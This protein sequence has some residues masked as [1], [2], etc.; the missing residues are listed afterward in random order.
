VPFSIALQFEDDK[1]AN[2]E[3]ELSLIKQGELV[4]DT[5]KDFVASSLWA[6]SNTIVNYVISDI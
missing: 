3:E 1:D 4:D 2:E 5:D 6:T